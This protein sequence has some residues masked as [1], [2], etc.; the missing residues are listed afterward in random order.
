MKGSII[1][2]VELSKCRISIRKIKGETTSNP[3]STPIYY[4]CQIRGGD[5][6]RFLERFPRELT[7]GSGRADADSRATLQLGA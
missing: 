5:R 2:V 1:T 6:K 3:E 7:Q 4:E